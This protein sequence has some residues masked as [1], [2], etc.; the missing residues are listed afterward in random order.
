MPPGQGWVAARGNEAFDHIRMAQR[1]ACDH[2]AGKGMADDDRLADAALFHQPGDRIGLTIRPGVFR[3]AALGKA[4]AG[5]VDEQHLGA[6]L[7][8]GTEGRHLV[9]HVAAGA[10][11]EDDGRQICGRACGHEHAV[12]AEAADID[13][14]AGIGRRCRQPAA[15][16][17]LKRME[18]PRASASTRRVKARNFV[19]GVYTVDAACWTCAAAHSVRRYGR[20]LAAV[21]APL[22]RLSGEGV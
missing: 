17:W 8:Q 22:R 9:Q 5:A 20:A 13:A 7:Q 6:A 19:M 12:H 4:V 16:H 2:R 14:L 18:A 1:K 3:P 21:Q 15:S 11:D 10:V